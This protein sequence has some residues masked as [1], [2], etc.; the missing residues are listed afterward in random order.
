M[1]AVESIESEKKNFWGFLSKYPAS[2]LHRSI[3][4]LQMFVD[5][6]KKLKHIADEHA[7]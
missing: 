1:I 2:V 3:E 7:E 5:M 6:L 4:V